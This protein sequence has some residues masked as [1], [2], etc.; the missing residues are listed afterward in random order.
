MKGPP[1]W[2]RIERTVVV[3]ESL[4]E[5]SSAIY[6]VYAIIASPFERQRDY[7]WSALLLNSFQAMS[8]KEEI[9]RVSDMTFYSSLFASIY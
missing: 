9:I 5:L 6:I 1:R 3:L 7:S 4:L 8:F 2:H